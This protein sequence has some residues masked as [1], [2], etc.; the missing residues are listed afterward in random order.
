MTPCQAGF[1]VHS[2]A[3]GPRRGVWA[4]PELWLGSGTFRINVEIIR[5][6]A[7]TN[8]KKL[9]DAEQKVSASIPEVQEQY[10]HRLQARGGESQLV[11]E[12]G[13]ARGGGVHLGQARREGTQRQPPEWGTPEAGWG[14]GAA[15]GWRSHPRA[16]SPPCPGVLTKA[17]PPDQYHSLPRAGC[18]V[19]CH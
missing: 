1:R 4:T 19:Q 17:L 2:T 5:T 7:G 15:C 13:V 16:A 3:P 10:K 12:A 11:D 9:L 6:E 18:S 8:L 14:P